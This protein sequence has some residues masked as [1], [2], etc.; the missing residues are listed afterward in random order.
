MP[1]KRTVLWSIFFYGLALAVRLAYFHDVRHNPLYD[2][3]TLDENTNHH[4]ALAVLNGTDPPKAYL[5]APLHQWYLLAV[6]RVFGVSTDTA[7]LV[8]LFLAALWAPLTFLIAERL[9]ARPADLIAGLLAVGFWTFVFFSTELLD[10]AI[11]GVFYLLTACLLVRLSDANRWKWLLVGITIGLGAI[12]RPNIL[13]VAPTLVVTLLIVAWRTPRAASSDAS[14]MRRG[15]PWRDAI[16]RVIALAIGCGIVILPITVRNRMVGGEWVLI[17]TYG[18][19]NFYLANNPESD[20][21]NVELLGLPDY[22][23]SNEYDANDPFNVHCFTYRQGCDHTSQKLRRPCTRGEMND[24]MMSL[25]RAY[26]RQYPWKFPGDSLKRFC[27]FFNSYEFADNKDLYQFCDFS[28]LLKGLSLLH[29]GI[30][31]PFVILG[32]ILVLWRGPRNASLAYYLMMMAALIGPGMFFLVNARFRA[33]IVCLLVPLGAHGLVEAA[34]LCRRSVERHKTYLAAAVLCLAAWFSNTNLFDY[35]PLCHPYLMFIYAAA[36]G[37]TGRQDEMART[38]E[39]IEQTM[40]MDMKAGRH[41]RAL[42][43]LYDYYS[44]RD[45][46]P[47]ATFYG[48]MMIERNQLDPPTAKRVFITAVKANDRELAEVVLRFLNMGLQGKDRAFAAEAMIEY[49]QRYN[50]RQTL[51]EAAQCYRRLSAEFPMDLEF[52]N[53]IRFVDELLARPTTTQAVPSTTTRAQ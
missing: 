4:V 37:A 24:M 43:C 45:N 48:R 33:V 39:K 28:R 41:G 12:T 51:Q 47:K 29:Y 30:L 16:L 34:R 5:K 15:G 7:R 9:F 26:V 20:A 2:W 6:Y 35:R 27:W 38:I 31:C 52:H 21:R 1:D 3:P 19:V 18:G 44:Q 42:F 50:D 17:A 11:A 36:C 49:A 8:Q 25:G 46:L 53:R 13:M 10:V 23:P 32:L 22:V 40:A 14:T